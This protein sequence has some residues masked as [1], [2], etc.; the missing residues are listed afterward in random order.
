MEKAFEAK[1]LW[2]LSTTKFISPFFFTQFWEKAKGGPREEEEGM[3]CEFE[4]E[5]DEETLKEEV[6]M[7]KA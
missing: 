5:G 1:L 4:V 2:V 7:V 3:F 6:A